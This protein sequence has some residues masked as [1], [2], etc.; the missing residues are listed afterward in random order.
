MPSPPLDLLDQLKLASTRPTEPETNAEHGRE[1]RD[2][3]IGTG[4][5]STK[6][7]T[8]EASMRQPCGLS[9]FNSADLEH[10]AG[11]RAVQQRSCVC[12]VL[13]LARGRKVH[14]ASPG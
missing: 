2:H 9:I 4:I 3:E 7:G 13:S 11:H 14:Q 8:F 10:R 5:L 6:C 1:L 12:L